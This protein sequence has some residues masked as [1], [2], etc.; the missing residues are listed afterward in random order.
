MA[1]AIFNRNAEISKLVSGK[2][3]EDLKVGQVVRRRKAPLEIE[4]KLHIEW[5]EPYWVVKCI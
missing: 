3:P 5:S 4:N 2:N 1:K